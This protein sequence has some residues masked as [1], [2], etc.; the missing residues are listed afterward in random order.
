MRSLILSQCG[1]LRMGVIR[2]DLYKYEESMTDIKL[3]LN[4]RH[5]QI[6]TQTHKK[7][8]VQQLSQ[9][10]PNITKHQLHSINVKKSVC[11]SVHVSMPNVI[12]S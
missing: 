4:P 2:L 3:P 6:D 7:I 12:T 10:V 1:D 8:I 11:A 5:R 9:T